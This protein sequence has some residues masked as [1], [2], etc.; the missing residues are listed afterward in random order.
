MWTQE[1]RPGTIGALLSAGASGSRSVS[2][3]RD[4]TAVGVLE[5]AS[6]LAAAFLRYG[7][8]PGCRIA[9]IAPDGAEAL[10]AELAAQIAGLVVVPI[11]PAASGEQLRRRLLDSEARIALAAD[12]DVFRRILP[13]RPELTALDLILLFVAPGGERVAPATTVAQA[14]RNGERILAEEPAEIRRILAGPTR[15]TACRL[16]IGEHP[17]GA[18]WAQTHG[19]IASAVEALAKAVPLGPGDRVLVGLPWTGGAARAIQ[20]HALASGAS[21]AFAPAGANL[22]AALRASRPTLVASTRE[23]I[24]AWAIAARAEI[25]GGRWPA[26]A[27]AGWTIGRASTR[28]DTA[29]SERR[30]R[31]LSGRDLLLDAA[32]VARPRSKATGGA[33]RRLVSIGRPLDDGLARFLFGLDLACFEALAVD[34]VAGL[35][36]VAGRD[37][38]CPGSAGRPLPGLEVAITPS[39]RV[40]VRGGMV[41]SE[42]GANAEGW[43]ETSLSA[44]LDPA[45]S[46]RL[47]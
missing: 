15:S 6:A 42:P 4:C 40:R 46:L 14:A 45:G 18:V 36:S 3:D 44:R 28:F 12:G 25:F 38:W 5:R 10:L 34:E 29:R 23:A 20:L 43:V 30:L 24:E 8:E 33:L 7:A 17:G 19:N 13:H 39:G 32:T 11:D 35:V 22:G 31:D 21:L 2:T 1:I 9:L 41:S 26:R 27:L 47:S 37:T 16:L